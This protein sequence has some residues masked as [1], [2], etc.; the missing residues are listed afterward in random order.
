MSDKE[1]IVKLEQLVK[2]LTGRVK[3]LESQL[4][5]RDRRISQLEKENARLTNQLEELQRV[6]ARQAAPFRRREDKKKDDKDK[7]PPGSKPGHKGHCR[8]VPKKIDHQE[9]APLDECPICGGDLTDVHPI[10]QFIE[11]IPPVRPRVIRL[12]TYWG[13]CKCCGEV[14]SSHPLQ[15][16]RGKG[17]AKVQLG[18][19]AL[20]IAAS[21]NKHMGLTMRKT[22]RVL[23]QLFGLKLTAGGLSQALD[24]VAKRLK[25]RY[26]A[27]IKDIRGS[28]AV[29][30]DETSWWVGGPGWWLWGFTADRTT[31]YRVD[32]SRGSDVVKDVLGHDY[33]GVLG[34]DCLSSYDPI[35]CRKHKC[36]A[37]HLRAIAEARELPG[38]DDGA[39]LD[40]WKMLFKAVIVVHRL[41]TEGMFTKDE[42]AAKR[43]RLANWADE[44]LQRPLSQ[45]GDVRIRN[46]LMKQRSHLLTCL[47]DLAANPTNN[48]AERALRPA[49]IARKVSCGN[50]TDQGRRT[51]QILASLGQTCS[52]R[53]E[54]FLEYISRN[55]TLQPQPR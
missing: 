45:T 32:D 7:H 20:A 8:P 22:C 16:S 37:H 49:V 48:A 46:R 52:Q 6:N 50:K 54:D 26:D 5:G 36:I 29:N 35:D 18:P 24:R 27:L 15:T 2:T 14:H 3:K 41:A 43:Q 51:W 17:A 21:L 47:E 53:G 25:G 23:E 39:Y 28:P 12:I 44:L 33:A 4:A 1:R 9:E 10:E 34:S 19:R 31:L 40:Q 42:L 11:E 55:I 13:R 30:A 38:Q